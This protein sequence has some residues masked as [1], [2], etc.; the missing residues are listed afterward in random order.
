[1]NNQEKAN[2]KV[3]RQAGFYIF[4]MKG[5]W[6]THPKLI[7]QYCVTTKADKAIKDLNDAIKSTQLF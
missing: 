5:F 6:A 1:M 7:C 4:E 2:A 3:L